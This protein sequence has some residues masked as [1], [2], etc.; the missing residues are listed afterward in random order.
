MKASVNPNYSPAYVACHVSR[1]LFCAIFLMLA[2]MIS[3]VAGFGFS[4]ADDPENHAP[5]LERHQFTSPHMGT[6]FRIVLYASSDSLASAAAD[7]AFRR[8]EELNDIMSDYIPDSELN[9]LAATAGSGNFVPVSGPLF[10]VLQTSQMVSAQTGGA[11]D[12]TSGP[13]VRLWREMRRDEDPQLPGKKAL[14]EASQSVG[15]KHLKLDESRQKAM[16]E[17]PGMKLDL[18]GIAKGYAAD[19]IRQVLL[20]FGIE[21]VLIDAGGDMVT[22]SAP[23]GRDGWNI[24]VPA[25][26]E[27]DEPD[28]FLLTLTHAAVSTSGD[29]YQFVEIDGKRYSHIID[30]KTG[31]GITEQRTVTVI[32]E[33]AMLADAYSTALSVLPIPDGLALIDR[34]TGYSSYFEVID[35]E[36]ITPYETEEF[37]ELRENQNRS[38][39]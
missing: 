31:I 6:L 34:K 23:P 17:K 28:P 16:L 38:D 37:T 33:S 24:A 8:I 22:G 13:F 36:T 26:D 29:L 27:H 35:G 39:R 21:S 7:S 9:H 10:E 5:A 18:G 11:F 30:P 19:E 14:R 12:I 25:H 1:S 3:P 20:H 32:G 15:Y 4:A 2:I